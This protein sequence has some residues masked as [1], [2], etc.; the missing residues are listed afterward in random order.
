L[1]FQSRLYENFAVAYCALT[2]RCEAEGVEAAQ[3][4]I[5]LDR[6]LGLMD[7]LAAWSRA[8]DCRHPKPRSYPDR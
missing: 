7:H 3:M 1:G 6:H 8:G 4:A 2:D 5:P